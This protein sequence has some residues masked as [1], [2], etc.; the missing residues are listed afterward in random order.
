[1]IKRDFY[2]EGSM[3]AESPDQDSP[4]ISSYLEAIAARRYLIARMALVPAIV[5]M[6]AVLL[7]S[8]RYTVSSSF[9]PQPRQSS[10]S[11]S[12]GLAAQ[13]GA[14]LPLG[15]DMTQ[16]PQF[17][18][19][20]V[21]SRRILEPVADSS[22]TIRDARG[23]VRVGDLSVQFEVHEPTAGLRREEAIRRLDEKVSVKMSTKTGVIGVSVTT[24]NAMLSKQIVDHLLKE[25]NRFNIE[26][27]QSQA[28]A[29]R[30]FAE[31]RV[32]ELGAELHQAEDQ[33]AQFLNQNRGQVLP[34]MLS[35]EAQRL[36]R[37]VSMRQ[38]IYTTMMQQ[39]EQAR[40]EEVRSTP[41][42]TTVEAPELPIKPDPRRLVQ[43][44]FIAFFVGL[45]FGIVFVV[46]IDGSRRERA[47]T[48]DE[49][50]R[51]GH[52]LWIDLW[53]P[54]RT[55]LKLMVGDRASRAGEV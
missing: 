34:P 8:R 7:M 51:L 44:T 24:K 22:Y 3:Q 9:V 12:L 39:Y 53:H 25:V 14:M 31:Q 48:G 37:V 11:G 18:V 47:A 40:I 5:V 49:R 10:L 43:K 6:V 33:Q 17:Y 46:L 29:E 20:L 38:D 42:V 2:D 32:Q 28:R 41:V 52:L 15:M 23:D 36:A 19:D 27:R 45:I 13:L 26:S 21:S 1:M 35:L 30:Q 55:L 50:P 4:S 54:F 16:S